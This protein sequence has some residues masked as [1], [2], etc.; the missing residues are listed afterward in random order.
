MYYIDGEIDRLNNGQI[1]QTMDVLTG[2][3]M[4]YWQIDGHIIGRYIDGL[5]NGQTHRRTDRNIQ[6]KECMDGG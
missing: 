5:L 4:E 3:W 6:L 2:G 1:D